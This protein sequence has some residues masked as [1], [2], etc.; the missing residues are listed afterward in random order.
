MIKGKRW[1][2]I[3]KELVKSGMKSILKG[4]INSP[5]SILYIDE[6]P[7]AQSKNIDARNSM[8][9]KSQCHTDHRT[10]ESILQLDRQ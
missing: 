10:H 4:E 5:F 2:R 6:L 8:Q 1:V 3:L 7:L 9:C